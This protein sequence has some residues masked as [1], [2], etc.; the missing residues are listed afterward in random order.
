M[1]ASRILSWLFQE[2][3]GSFK[4]QGFWVQGLSFRAWGLG[5][6]VSW[7]RARGLFFFL[8]VGFWSN[9]LDPKPSILKPSPR[10]P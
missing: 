2:V 10:N 9:D 6:R 5:F 4:G 1:G 8:G 3:Q 7:F